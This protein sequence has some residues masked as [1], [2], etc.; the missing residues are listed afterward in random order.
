M[1]PVMADPQI[2]RAADIIRNATF[3]IA[4]SGAGV[5][6]P[7]GIPDFRSPN[8]GLWQTVDPMEAAS[9][10]GF[11]EHPERFY[12]WFLPIARRI[13]DA[14]PNPAHAALAAMEQAGKLQLLITQNIDSLHQQAGSRDVVE[15]HG[16]LRGARC[17]G[18]QHEVSSHEMWLRL[19][20]GQVA[21]CGGCNGLLKPNAILF[22]EPLDYA[23]L[24]RSQ[25]GALFCDVILAVG[26][27]LEVEP[28]ADLPYLA[29]RRGAARRPD[30]S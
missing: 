13:R 26:T 16:N 4:L 15:L 14:S 22:G 9:I 21:R 3:V 25:E 28:A 6:T 10:W 11:V 5:S 23:S 1:Y 7:S 18:C 17:L 19:D 27:S 8:A 24:R 2:R 12:R 30:Q 20:R 29:R